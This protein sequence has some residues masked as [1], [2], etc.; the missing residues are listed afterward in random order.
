[1]ADLDNQEMFMFAKWYGTHDLAGNNSFWEDCMKY[2]IDKTVVLPYD[3]TPEQRESISRSLQCPAGE[4]G[5][6][7]RYDRV[8]ITESEYK[9]ISENVRQRILV[10]TDR[11]GKMYLKSAGGCQFLKNDA[12]TIYN[13]RPTVCRAFPIISPRK[14]A[15]E[16]GGEFEQLQ[17]KIK[18]KPSLDAIR[19]LVNKVCSGGKL[20]LLPDLSIIPTFEYAGTILNQ[21][22][23]SSAST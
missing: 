23:E 8:A 13:F 14:T 12:C 17:L 11:D 22:V 19:S 15:S 3:D 10:E 2:Y 16:D 6:C 9:L 18:C 7:C 1:L 20:M 4:C 5:E 21:K